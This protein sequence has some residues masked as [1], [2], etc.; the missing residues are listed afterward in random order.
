MESNEEK[1]FNQLHDAAY[2]LSTALV[3]G[4]PKGVID[5]LRAK[6]DAVLNGFWE[7]VEEERRTRGPE[8]RADEAA[9]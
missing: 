3:A 6:V 7:A 5:A 8:D 1:H 9:L 2:D 4:K